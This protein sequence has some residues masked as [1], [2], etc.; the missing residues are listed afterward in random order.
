MSLLLS[1][2]ALPARASLSLA[3]FPQ[4]KRYVLSLAQQTPTRVWDGQL[5]FSAPEELVIALPSRFKLTLGNA[6]VSLGYGGFWQ[7]YLLLPL[8]AREQALL[9]QADR[10]AFALVLARTSD[11]KAVGYEH[12]LKRLKLSALAWMQEKEVSSSFQTEWGAKYSRWGV[13]AKVFLATSILELGAELLFTPVQGVVSFVSTAYRHGSSKLSFVYGQEPYPFRYSVNIALKSKILQASFVM[14]D[15]FGSKP[16]YGGFSSMR[17]RRQSSDLRFSLAVGYLLFSFS[18]TYEFKQRGSEVGSVLMQATWG[19]AF[20]QVS[21]QFGESR[22]L[23][24]R[25]EAQYRLSLVV[26]KATLSYTQEGY[27]MG[28][29]DSVAIGK[30]IGTWKLNTSMGKAITLSLMYAVTSDR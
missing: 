27:E 29:S 17:K 12:T 21:A 3:I 15:W 16:I 23:S 4:D 20:G 5:T 14:E 9:Y 30:G 19:G 28:I 24:G 2:W 10:N 6:Q 25:G 13:G 26:Y 11:T 18:D 8:F 7:E 22:A 1:L